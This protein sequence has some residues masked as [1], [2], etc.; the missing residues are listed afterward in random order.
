MSRACKHLVL[1]AGCRMQDAGLHQKH[2]LRPRLSEFSHLGKFT[3]PSFRSR[4]S[5][6][7]LIELLVVIAIIA[8]LLAI[9]LPA[10]K[11]AKEQAKRILCTGNFKQNG[12]AVSNYSSDNDDW[13]PPRFCD[14]WYAY[15]WTSSDPA[16][17]HIGGKC[18]RYSVYYVWRDLYP[19]YTQNARIFFCA[20]NTSV[21]YESHFKYDGNSRSNYWWMLRRPP[22]WDASPEPRRINEDTVRPK[23]GFTYSHYPIAQDMT[24]TIYTSTMNHRTGLKLG[25][26]FLY[27]DGSVSFLMQGDSGFMGVATGGHE[28]H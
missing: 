4:V 6:F 25:G 5:S 12:V 14:I 21:T 22:Y 1:D 13:M 26:N 11:N 19:T 20:S 18:T 27:V 9:L 15:T 28:S 3:S 7:T 8:I 17:P 23:Y 10:L 16:E 24:S 2:D